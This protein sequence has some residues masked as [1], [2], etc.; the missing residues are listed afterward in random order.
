MPMTIPRLAQF[1]HEVVEVASNRYKIED[2]VKAL[3]YK[4]CHSLI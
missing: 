1:Y 2:N 3:Q 4:P